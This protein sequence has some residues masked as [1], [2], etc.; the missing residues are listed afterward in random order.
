MQLPATLVHLLQCYPFISSDIAIAE[1]CV[2]QVVWTPQL[3]Q[4][5]KAK[6]DRICSSSVTYTMLA[7]R[8]G[9]VVYN[10]L[11]SLSAASQSVTSLASHG[12][13]RRNSASANTNFFIREVRLMTCMRSRG[14]E[15]KGVRWAV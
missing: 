8:R 12:Q 10:S 11:K 2:G 14:Y 6:R 9:R 7:L 13:D 4:Y 15:K 5:K 3:S 1:V